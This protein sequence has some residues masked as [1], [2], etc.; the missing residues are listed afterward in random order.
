MGIKPKRQK[1]GKLSNHWNAQ[2]VIYTDGHASL[3]RCRD[4]DVFFSSMLIQPRLSELNVK[5]T[6]Y[7]HPFTDLSY[8]CSE[9]E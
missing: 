8:I 1:N 4:P 3:L 5:N 9:F 6:I 2:D 7:G